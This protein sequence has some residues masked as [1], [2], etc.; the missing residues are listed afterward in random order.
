MYSI[1]RY[2]YY[3]DSVLKYLPIIIGYTLTSEI[4]GV[5]IRDFDSFQL[6][7]IEGYSY[8]N[9]LI[10]N[11]FDI[12]FFLFF[13]FVYRRAVKNDINKRSILV[14]TVLFVI[15]AIINPFFQNALIFPQMYTII[16]GSL[17]LI[18][19]IVFY[20]YEH[21]SLKERRPKPN[22]LVWISIGLLIFYFFYPIIISIGIL[23]SDLYQRFAM[24]KILRVLI[25]LM[26]GFFIVGFARMKKPLV[27]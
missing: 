19:C 2:R 1:I 27:L 25:V 22:L 13:F 21:I 23:D 8:Y 26:Y 7:Y 24:H 4:L 14:A 3:F 6:I 15:T 9:Q 17:I 16:V 20:L 12:V 18:I 10:F 5:L 11:I